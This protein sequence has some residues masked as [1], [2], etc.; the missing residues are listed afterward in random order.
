MIL[1]ILKNLTNDLEKYINE[2]LKTKRRLDT[3]DE[4]VE[5]MRNRESVKNLLYLYKN[6]KGLS[7]LI[8]QEYK[9]ANNNDEDEDCSILLQR[10]TQLTVLQDR[11]F[12][13]LS[14]FKYNIIQE[15]DLEQFRVHNIDL[16]TDLSI[17]KEDSNK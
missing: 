12:D 4:Y 9:M 6:T 11:W 8:S 3:R 10:L 7:L 16:N 15:N 1:D 13:I 14:K 5:Y 2:L 17:S